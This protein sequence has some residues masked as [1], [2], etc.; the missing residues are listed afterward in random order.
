LQTQP[1]FFKIS[2]KVT[3]EGSSGT[4]KVATTFS[5]QI[6]VTTKDVISPVVEAI[7]STARATGEVAADVTVDVAKTALQSLAPD[8]YGFLGNW[9]WMILLTCALCVLSV[10][11]SGLVI[12]FAK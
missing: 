5:N 11:S 6:A 8:L 1:G 3:N 4:F 10:A 2:G 12:F 7:G 9:W